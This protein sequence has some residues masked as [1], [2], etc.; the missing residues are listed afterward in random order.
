MGLSVHLYL[1][2]WDIVFNLQ[3]RFFDKYNFF[4][5][6]INLIYLF[7]QVGINMCLLQTLNKWKVKNICPILLDG[8]VLTNYQKCIMRECNEERK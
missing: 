2:E 8:K 7:I 3:N 4:R 5:T 1:W 6:M